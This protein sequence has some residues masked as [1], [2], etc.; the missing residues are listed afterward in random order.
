M[1]SPQTAHSEPLRRIRPVR[2]CAAEVQVDRMPD[3]TVLLKSARTLPGY[4]DKLTDRLVHWANA[5]P[6]R[7]FMAEHPPQG[8]GWRSITY[9]QTL[10]QVRRI[11]AALTRRN[12]S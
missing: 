6:D 2:L 11:G 12:L 4:P 1:A 8:G 10:D 3:G 9:A 7:V 5:A